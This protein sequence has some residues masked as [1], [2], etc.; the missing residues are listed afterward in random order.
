MR[1]DLKKYLFIGSKK[2]IDSFFLKAQELGLIHF[3]NI[4]KIKIKDVPV[5]IQ[6]ATHAIKI[7]RGQPVLPQEE[8]LIDEA[9]SIV[10][11]ILELDNEIN[12]LQEKRRSTKLD[13]ARTDVFGEF[14]LEDVRYIANEGGYLVRFFCSKMGV[15]DIAPISKDLIFVGSKF[16]LDYFVS[17]SRDPVSYDKMIEMKVDRELNDLHKSIED[18]SEEIECKEAELRQYA[19]YNQYLH[20]SLLQKYNHSSLTTAQNFSQNKLDGHLFAI[21]GWAPK[22]QFSELKSAMQ[23]LDVFVDEIVVE[24]QDIVPTFLENKGVA[25]IGED[26]VHIYDTPGSTDKDP[27]LWVLFSFALFFAMI[28]N[29]GGY[30][31]VF[32]GAA[33][34]VRYKYAPSGKQGVRMWKL[35]TILFSFCVVW[36]VFTNSFFGLN[37]SPDSPFRKVSILHFLSEKKWPIFYMKKVVSTKNGLHNIHICKVLKIRNKF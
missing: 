33:L 24:E 21:E 14:S 26:L 8:L 9:D 19:K 13:I 37:F 30:G 7:I 4:G 3:I 11:N 18:L 16:D 34:Y 10:K 6:N 28:I 27:S 25:K 2:N 23:N 15:K 20:N 17:V 12:A 31:A 29:D 36:G 1:L 5:E 35:A 32:L 22:K